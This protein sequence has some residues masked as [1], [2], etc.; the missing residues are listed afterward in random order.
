MPTSTFSSNANRADLKPSSKSCPCP[1][2]GRTKDGD[3]R[4]H[5]DGMVL[6]RTHTGN[7][8]KPGDPAP[9]G[10]PY[11]FMGTSTKAYD[12]GM[13]KPAAE[14]TD[15]GRL[16]ASTHRHRTAALSPQLKASAI[17]A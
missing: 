2:C 12:L 7:G 16:Q 14:W 15:R 11:R 4:I 1:M 8:L 3:C 17:P 9:S 6:C 10:A 5:S 13:W